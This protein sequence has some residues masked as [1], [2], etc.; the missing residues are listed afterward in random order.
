MSDQTTT[1]RE[2]RDLLTAF[3]AE[4]EWQPFHDPQNLAASIAIEAPELL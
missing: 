2:L 1:V 3:V 4:R